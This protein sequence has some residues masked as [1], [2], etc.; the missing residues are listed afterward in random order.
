MQ[1]GL[2]IQASGVCELEQKCGGGCWWVEKKKK[3]RKKR[4]GPLHWAL[5]W[6]KR[7]GLGLKE[8]GSNGEEGFNWADLASQ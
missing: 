2:K 6:A 8:F 4:N 3:K 5:V 1:V 7:N